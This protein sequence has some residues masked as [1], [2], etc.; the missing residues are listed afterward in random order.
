MYLVRPGVAV[1]PTPTYGS[2]D[3]GRWP[4]STIPPPIRS[5]T[6]SAW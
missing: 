4:H 2:Q 5:L 6:E 3:G 1:L